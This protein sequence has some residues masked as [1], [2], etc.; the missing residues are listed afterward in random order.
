MAD[1]R[2][3]LSRRAALSLPAAA[4]LP[5]SLL[6]PPDP[7][8]ADPASFH[9]PPGFAFGVSSSAYQIEGAV[10]DDGR[11][12]SIWDEFCHHPCRVRGK[13][14]ADIAADHYHRMEQDVALLAASG[15]RHYRFSV[16]WPRL[17]PQGD[18]V[19][20]AKGFA[21]Y[22]RLLDAL[23]A[24][25]I[26]PWLTLYHWDLPQPLQAKGGWTNRDTAYRFADFAAACARHFGNRVPNWLATNEIAVHAYIG[27][28]LGFHAPGLTGAE[29]WFA[30]L[31]H[32][33]LGQGL[34]IQAVR[35]QTRGR[36]G[37]VAAC[38]PIRPSSPAPADV[39]AAKL[40]DA[41]W[42]G[43]VLEPL[44]FGRYPDA[45]ADFTAPHVRTAD[46]TLLA[47]PLDMLGINYY[48]RLYIAHNPA[49]PLSVFFGANTHRSPYFAG[50]WPIE[51][52]GLYEILTHIQS[53]YAPR[54]IFISENGYA[55]AADDPRGEPL[56]DI[57]RISYIAQHLRFLRKSM[58]AGV[59][60][61]GYFVWSLLDSFEWN[62]GMKW[63][64]GMVAV[65][66]ATLARTPKRSYHWYGA[67]A[68]RPAVIA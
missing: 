2:T 34:A 51:P 61:G 18:L 11:G 3:L 48:S 49:W 10:H 66:F 8:P 40:F 67:L 13:Q 54:E 17:F 52:D 46:A 24:H 23:H 9:F 41:A 58:D 15:V 31:H 37:T 20:N 59:P 22:D 64:F 62:D 44:F 16:S 36:V 57:A 14:N 1:F 6:L 12:D 65:D 43:G 38:E 21:F 53:H 68:R 50:G 19:P 26:T 7:A 27:H 5:P 28:C 55:S 33:N 45:I 4:A 60:V 30:A 25:G 63:R 29:N 32:L 56:N 35:A 42:N 39:A 47:P